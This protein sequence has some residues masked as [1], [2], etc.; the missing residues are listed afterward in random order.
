MRNIIASIVLT[1]LTL[2]AVL[3][4]LASALLR[5]PEAFLAYGVWMMRVGQRLFGINGRGGRPRPAR[6]PDA[7]CLHV[8][9]PELPRRAGNRDRHRPARAFD[10]QEIRLPHPRLRLGHAPGRLRARRQ[11]GHRRG[12]EAHRPRIRAHPGKGLFVP[13]LSRRSAQLGR[14]VAAVSPRR[15]LPGPRGGSPHRARV[16]P[17]DLRADAPRTTWRIRRGRVRIIFHEPVDVSGFTPEALPALM[18][19][20]RAAIASGLTS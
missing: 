18:E 19:R 2:P 16:R 12:P 17:G 8:Q 6:S 3:V 7:L 1:V 11:G 5:R 4:L 15:V 10:R 20:V 14:P 13:R 9:P